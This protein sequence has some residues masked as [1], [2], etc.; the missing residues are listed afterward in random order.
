[1]K[2]LDDIL[3]G[4]PIPN[5]K[6]PEETE[7]FKKY[8]DPNFVHDIGPQL[9]INF[10]HEKFVSTGDGYEACLYIYKYPKEVTRHW[11]NVLANKENTIIVIDVAS[12]NP[13]EIK[14]NLNRSMEE[15]ASRYS[16]AK[17]Q[18]QRLDAQQQFSEAEA[19]YMEVAQYGNV[20]KT[21][22]IRIYIPARSIVECDVRC[23]ELIAELEGYGYKVGICINETKQD[24]RNVFLSYSQQQETLYRR[25]GQAMLSTTL[26]AGNP[27]H[28]TKLSDPFGAYY[29]TTVTGGSVLLD[30]FRVTDQRMSYNHILVGKMGSGKSTTLKKML[31][32]RASR[33]DMIRVFDVTGEFK[34]LC[35]YLGGKIINLDGADKKIINALQILPTDDNLRISYNMH[36]AKVAT[37]YKYLKADASSNEIL[38]LKKLLRLLYIHW[39]IVDQNGKIIVDLKKMPANAFPT[40]SDFLSFI[41]EGLSSLAVLDA[42]EIH[43]DENIGMG[44]EKISDEDESVDFSDIRKSKEAYV[45]NIELIVEDICLSYG[46]LF[47]GHTTM[48]DFYAEQ[49]VCFDITN[50][51]AMEANVFDAQLFSALSLCWDNCVAIG[52]V[53][54]YKHD[55]QEIDIRDVTRF[56]ILIDEAHRIVNAKKLAGVELITLFEREARK[57]FGGIALASQSIRDFVPDDSETAAANQIKTLFDLST[58][59]WIM[60]QDTNCKA[61]LDSIFDGTFTENEIERVPLLGKGQ[62]ILSVSAGSNLELDIECSREELALFQG[63][64]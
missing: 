6:D 61:K 46:N 1:M 10:S 47:D 7:K 14:K 17:T 18:S 34:T 11:L 8:V 15:H 44:D 9:G 20:M 50:L 58:Y 21:I 27:F 36:I 45:E 25:K 49:I 62:V 28:F 19:M 31:L 16:S 48:D 38:I 30:T 40:W 24:Y 29:G 5:K 39:G 59:K 32:E 22:C 51:A 54:K 3:K 35:H 56:M 26:A 60:N 4:L 42:V 13:T 53:M 43:E 33:G 37:I 55:H 23:G 41:K 2:I 63:G 57:Y 64:A 12:L 52:K